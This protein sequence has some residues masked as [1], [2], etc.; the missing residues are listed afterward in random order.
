MSVVLGG[1]VLQKIQEKELTEGDLKDGHFFIIF[2]HNQF[3]KTMV[4]E[5]ALQKNGSSKQLKKSFC[6]NAPCY[7]AHSN[8]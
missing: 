1:W 3:T 7:N 6:T 4:H 8:N 5:I 2:G